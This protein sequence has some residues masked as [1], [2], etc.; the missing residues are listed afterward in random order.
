MAADV[1]DDAVVPAPEN[2]VNLSSGSPDDSTPENSCATAVFWKG[3]PLSVMVSRD[4][5]KR[6]ACVIPDAR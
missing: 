4:G 6:C 5:G 1:P 3:L 2:D